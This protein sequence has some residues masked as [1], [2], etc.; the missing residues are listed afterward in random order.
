MARAVLDIGK[1]LAKV[2]LWDRDG[3]LLARETR[4]NQIV[5]K[6][7]TRRLD[8]AGIDG[9]LGETL[10]R[11][12]PLHPIESIFPVGHGAAAV[13]VRSD[14]SFEAALD[15]EQGYSSAEQAQY[16]LIRDAYESTGSPLLPLGL[17]LGIQ[18]FHL[19][20][21]DPDLLEGATILP[22]PQFWAWRLCGVMANEVTSMGCH[23]DLWCP[24]SSRPS[25]LADRLG[26]AEHLAPLYAATDI[27]GTLTPEWI[28]RT[29][30]GADTE[31][32]CGIHDSNAALIAARA[33][34]EIVDEESTVLSTGTWFVAMRSPEHA[35]M[36]DIS[37]LA[38]TRDCL[39]NVDAFGK[40]VPSAR[41]MGGRE[42]E[43]QIEID[44]RRVD[45]KP[46]QPALLAA[47][48]E[49][50]AKGQMLLPT[51]A[52]GTGPFPDRTGQW[53]NKPDDWHARRAAVCIYAALLADQSLDLI[54]S[55][56]RLLIEGR[57]AEA[58]VFVR[59]LASLRPDTV[60]YVANAHNDVAFGAL[61]L[62]DPALQPIGQLIKT[63][64]LGTDLSAYKRQ[65]H[66]A[67]K[68]QKAA[69]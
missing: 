36:V 8:I 61:R 33:F 9:W 66:A 63:E 24:T 65:W 20:S 37:S 31:I 58:Q 34:P 5:E 16:K 15:Y 45:I 4:A 44:T 62:I 48:P 7:G 21:T 13:I 41:F 67:I 38:E 29:G 14:L 55:K 64:P 54:G 27:L 51:L 47:V 28:K 10:A 59:A 23:T 11:L 30:L 6:D 60:V 50:V 39:V 35:D 25:K 57:F 56:D 32:Y 69:A 46:D 12:A 3:C 22:W 2:T 68:G 19:I 40:P 53:I 26:L 49:I 17:N 42:I 18:L 1:T 52:P 43:T